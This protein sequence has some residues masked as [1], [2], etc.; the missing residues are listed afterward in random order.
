MH[1]IPLKIRS[2]PLWL[3]CFLCLLFNGVFHEMV[4]FSLSLPCLQ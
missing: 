2:F 3:S 1:E 4:R